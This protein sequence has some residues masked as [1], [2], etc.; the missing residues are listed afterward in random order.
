MNPFV[1]F[2]ICSCLSLGFSAKLEETLATVNGEAVYLSDYQTN[3]KNVLDDLRNTSAQEAGSS[4]ADEIRK[5]VLD[6]MIDDLLLLQEARRLKVRVYDK[7]LKAGVEEVK[8]RFRRDEEGRLLSDEETDKTFS[9]ELKR[10]RLTDKEFEE[11]IRKQLMVIKLV[12]QNIKSRVTPPTDS[13]LRDL[14][15]KLQLA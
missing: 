8:S 2:L 13:E 6:Q 15:G 5:K 3:T 4:Q 9:V 10:Q 11:R 7:D 12:D 14:F 1:L